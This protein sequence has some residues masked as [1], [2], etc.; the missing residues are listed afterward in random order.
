MGGDPWEPKGVPWE[1]TL[2]SSRDPMG[3]H[4]WEPKGSHGRGTPGTP[5]PW[6]GTL[7]SPR[8]P[9]VG[10]PRKPKPIGGD[11]W[12]PKGSPGIR[13]SGFTYGFWTLTLCHRATKNQNPKNQ[14]TLHKSGP[15][16]MFMGFW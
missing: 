10:G 14:E 8:D 6:E 7:E 1:G 13:F 12:E 5:S 9:M 3:G 11:P 2:G 15:G 16:F 4:A